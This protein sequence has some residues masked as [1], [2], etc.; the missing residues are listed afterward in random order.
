MVEELELG[1]G[2]DESRYRRRKYKK[3]S[4]KKIGF[5]ENNNS[6]VKKNPE[7]Y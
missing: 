3:C 1:K 4:A 7:I 2:Y 6:A 5:R